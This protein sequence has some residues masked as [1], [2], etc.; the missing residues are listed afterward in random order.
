MFFT[1]KAFVTLLAPGIGWVYFAQIIQMGGYALSV[2]ASVYYTNSLIRPKDRA[3][4][5][6][7]MTVT[8]T[9]G[10][11]LGSPIGGIILDVILTR[12]KVLC[13]T[14]GIDQKFHLSRIIRRGAGIADQAGEA[15][16]QHG[17]NQDLDEVSLQD[18]QQQIVVDLT[19]LFILKD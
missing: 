14:D 8:N 2:P 18:L 1:L 9:I 13:P 17:H 5:Q 16:D 11:V 6:A 3:K 7:Y 10:S 12:V 4:G 19:G 15:R